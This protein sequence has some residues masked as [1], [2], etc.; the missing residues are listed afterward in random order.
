MVVV[1]RPEDW[2]GVSRQ[3][4]KDLELLPVL[5]FDCEWVSGGSEEAPVAPVALLQIATISGLCV[6]LRW[7]NFIK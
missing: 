7:E 2:A 6:L 1:R 5:G 3:V 4:K